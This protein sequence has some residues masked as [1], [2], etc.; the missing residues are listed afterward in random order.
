MYKY[1][2]DCKHILP[3]ERTLQATDHHHLRPIFGKYGPR[4]SIFDTANAN[5]SEYLHLL[6]MNEW[7]FLILASY[8]A[9]NPYKFFSSPISARPEVVKSLTR[10]SSISSR[11]VRI[12]NRAH[13]QNGWKSCL[14]AGRHEKTTSFPFPSFF[15]YSIYYFNVYFFKNEKRGRADTRDNW[16]EKERWACKQHTA[17]LANFLSWRLYESVTDLQL[18]QRI[19]RITE[20]SSGQT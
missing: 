16:G 12:N 6:R 7:L 20:Q 11:F 10:E 18:S 14:E 8:P 2:K 9:P 5:M 17:R 1:F 13:S 4:L 3:R 19:G 15:S